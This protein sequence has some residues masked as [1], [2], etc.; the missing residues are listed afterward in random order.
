MIRDNRDEHPPPKSPCEQ[1]M[2]NIF[3]KNNARKR[4]KLNINKHKAM[5][6]PGRIYQNNK[7]LFI[8]VIPKNAC[9]MEFSDNL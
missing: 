4:R 2:N 9:K 6:I 3:K 1:N 5:I 8:T 7:K